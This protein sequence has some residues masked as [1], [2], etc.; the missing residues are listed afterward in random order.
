[1]LSPLASPNRAFDIYV[2]CKLGDLNQVK[3]LITPQNLNQVDFHGNTP[4]Y[5]ACLCGHF[6][7]VRY[8]SDLGARDD[9]FGRCYWNALSLGIRNLLKLYN[10]YKKI[11]GSSGKTKEMTEDELEEI[12]KQDSGKFGVCIETMA[13]RILFEKTKNVESDLTIRVKFANQPKESEYYCHRWVLLSRWPLL[14][15]LAI[16]KERPIPT[17]VSNVISWKILQNCELLSLKT[18]KEFEAYHFKKHPNTVL[19]QSELKAQIRNYKKM[20]EEFNDKLKLQG[21]DSY[22]ERVEN[23]NQSLPGSETELKTFLNEHVQCI[24]LG[25][26]PFKKKIFD[27]MLYYVYTG[28]FVDVSVVKIVERNVSSL[29]FG[30]DHD[31]FQEL[32]TLFETLGLPPMGYL[33]YN[34]GQ[35]VPISKKVLKLQNDLL[36]QLES[37]YF[38]ESVTPISKIYHLRKLCCN[39]KLAKYVDD[40]EE[41]PEPPSDAIL[42]NK[43]F[44]IMRSEFF[45]VMLNGQFQEAE[46]IREMESRHE[47]PCLELQ[48]CSNLSEL[49]RFIY[50]DR[51]DITTSNVFE[52]LNY[53]E[54]MGFEN[55]RLTCE[56]FINE[57][58]VADE[59]LVDMLRIAISFDLEK[60]KLLMERR[61]SHHL[62]EQVRLGNMTMEDVENTFLSVGYDPTSIQIQCCL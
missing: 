2:Y 20:V 24:D 27:E 29:L 57:M 14:L 31:H 11:F 30:Q 4:L 45:N 58:P 26:L 46:H 44:L 60:K 7:V 54:R 12:E 48:Q 21:M 23:L 22:N 8:L 6:A 62:V 41:F 42:C 61:L 36:D 10:D 47:L 52:L 15:E 43:A 19:L 25:E 32:M 28:K 17:K 38:L 13:K 35:H 49:M 51:A 39:F 56:E 16:N 9:N 34:N 33:T 3:R 50:S 40:D 18:N 53:A 55:L 59:Q 1:M 5:Y 37:S